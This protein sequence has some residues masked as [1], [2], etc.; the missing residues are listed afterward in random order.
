MKISFLKKL[1]HFQV[2][3]RYFVAQLDGNIYPKWDDE[4][5]DEALKIMVNDIINNCV[6]EKAWDIIETSITK[7]KKRKDSVHQSD[8]DFDGSGGAEN[9]MKMTKKKKKSGG[10]GRDKDPLTM[11]TRLF[12][13]VKTLAEKVDNLDTN[14][15]T[16]VLT[17]LDAALNT[18]V[19]AKIIPIIEKITT[20]EKE[21][22]YIKER[23]EAADTKETANSNVNI[24]EEVSSK[25]MSWMVQMKGTSHADLPIPCVVKNVKKARKKNA[26][27]MNMGKTLE[28]INRPEKK[29]N[30]AEKKTVLQEAEDDSL[31]TWSNPILS[32]K[33]KKL[34]VG[35]AIMAKGVGNLNDRTPLQRR[36]TKLSSTQ[37]PLFIRDSTVKRIIS[38]V[39]PSVM[40]YDPLAMVV[41]SK[42]QQL[43]NFIQR[44]EYV[45]LIV[46]FIMLYNKFDI[47]IV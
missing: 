12:T 7:T 14:L 10:D 5:E 27:K 2:C 22:K 18:K 36:Q 17:G 8:D 21:M 40:A 4:V 15:A 16:K 34:G 43:V 3:V 23:L 28:N 31:E 25:D 37:V 11:S 6:D 1:L 42:L 44:D 38:C 33:Y 46:F 9:S 45:I 29:N 32:E 41:D 35:L 30:V 19:D 39:T 20:L 24:H 13:M 26:T 47:S